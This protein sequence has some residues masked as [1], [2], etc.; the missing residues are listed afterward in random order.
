[1]HGTSAKSSGRNHSERLFEK[2]S[3][4]TKKKAGAPASRFDSGLHGLAGEERLNGNLH[5][6]RLHASIM[7]NLHPA[8]RDSQIIYVSVVSSP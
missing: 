2:S 3:S 1:M 5:L 4:R 7:L 6:P 8:A